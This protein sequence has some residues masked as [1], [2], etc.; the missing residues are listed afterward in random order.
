MAEFNV[1]RVAPYLSGIEEVDH[2]YLQL[3][4]LE[5]LRVK[6]DTEFF[7]SLIHAHG[8]ELNDFSCLAFPLHDQTLFSSVP[9][10]SVLISR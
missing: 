7:P 10:I 8:S 5:C 1:E 6:Q 9:S 2:L 4:H 3:I